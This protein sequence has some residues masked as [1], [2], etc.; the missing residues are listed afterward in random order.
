[1]GACVQKDVP[2]SRM[3]TKAVF[4]CSLAAVQSTFVN[5]TDA[6]MDGP[7]SRDA[8]YCSIGAP[9]YMGTISDRYLS[10]ISGL[11]YSRQAYNVLWV[12][13]D[14]D[15]APII[16]AISQDGRRLADVDLRGTTVRDWEDIAVNIENGISYIYLGDIGDNKNLGPPTRDSLT[17]YK[18][19][20]PSVS[21]DWSEHDIVINAEEIEHIHV[22][23]PAE[24]FDAEAMAVDPLNGD[25]LIF[26]KDHN[27]AVCNVFKVPHGAGAPKP[28]S[29]SPPSLFG[30][31]LGQTSPHLETP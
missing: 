1:M 11:A 13:N 22:R 16:N 12:H 29:T 2:G 27:N 15:G 5:W 25:I 19:K 9:V 24:I 26:T 18:F 14:S 23:Y 17:I 8:G 3:L 6:A 7:F 10:E 4:I 21:P 20:E 30:P 28:W 31:S